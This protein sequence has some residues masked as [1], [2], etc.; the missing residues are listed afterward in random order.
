MKIINLNRITKLITFKKG[1]KLGSKNKRERI[2]KI[3]N[4]LRTINA[5]SNNTR[6][7]IG[8]II[9]WGRLLR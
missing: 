6:R 9:R 5:Y 3:T 7:G 2:N 8:E 1:R 4:N